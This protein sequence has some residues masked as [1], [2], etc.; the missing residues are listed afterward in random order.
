VEAIDL[1]GLLVALTLAPNT[2]SRNR[3]FGMYTDPAAR[4]VHRRAALLRGVMKQLVAP[5]GP[6]AVTLASREEGGAMLAYEMPALGLRRTV[7]LEPL[8]LA[9]LRFAIA[10]G[11]QAASAPAQAPAEA[12]DAT[13]AT[14]APA[15]APSQ[16]PSDASAPQLAPVDPDVLAALRPEPTDAPRV[17]AALSRLMPKACYDESADP[18]A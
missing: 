13:G 4:K 12:A 9:V 14:D 17:E 5:Q 7:P 10:R 3:F 1:E 16:A 2:F 8:E 18:R 15:A 11:A 6:R